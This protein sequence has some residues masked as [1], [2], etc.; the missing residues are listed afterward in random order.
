MKERLKFV[1]EW[2]RRWEANEGRVNVSE[3]CRAFG[4]SR[5]TGHRLIREY[6]ASDRKPEAV[7]EKSRRPH[8]TPTKVDEDVE[9]FVVA[10]RKAHPTWGPKKLRSWIAD[11]YPQVPMPAPST[12]GEILKRRGLTVPRKRQRR[13]K[14]QSQPFADVAAC[15]TTWCVDFKG[16]FRTR[17]GQWCYPLTIV[18]AFSRFLVRCEGLLEPNGDNVESVFDSA[19]QEFGLP[20]AI[21]SDNGPPFVSTGAGGLTP[22]SVWWWKLGIRHE[23]IRPGKPQQNGRQER[24]HRTLKAECPPERDVRA[25]QRAFDLFRRE[26]NE[27]RP[28]EALDQQPPG[29]NYERSSRRYPRPLLQFA[30]D[31]WDITLRVDNHGFIRWNKQRIFVS[32]ALCHEEVEISRLG[33]VDDDRGCDLSFGPVLLGQLHDGELVPASERRKRVFVK[34]RLSGMSLD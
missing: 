23:R 21:R 13:S 5:D 33:S 2:E 29:R 3:L 15:N 11:R 12:V 28:H 17:D 20:T 8:S 31:P 34:E 26:Y 27:E 14:W 25:Q 18:D 4:V 22:L 32:S 7:R 30:S 1:L 9:A 19:F 24:F 10:A 16:Q 6:V